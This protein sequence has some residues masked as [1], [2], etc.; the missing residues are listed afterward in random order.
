MHKGLKEPHL[1]NVA[2]NPLKVIRNLTGILLAAELDKIRAEI[3]ANVVGLY[4]L[5]Q[6]HFTFARAVPALE[7]RQRVSRL[8]YGAYNVRRAIML[9][10]DGTFSTDSSDHQKTD[11]RTPSIML[12]RIA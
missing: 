9:K 6:L 7:W 12:P 4:R 8:Y 3:D 1:F 5:G 10:Y 11:Y 2:S